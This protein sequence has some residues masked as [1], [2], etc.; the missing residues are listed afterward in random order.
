MENQNNKSKSELGNEIIAKSTAKASGLAALP[1]PIL[2]VAGIIF[3]QVNM[4]E[5]LADLYNIEIENKN[6][7]F[8]SSVASSVITKLISELAGSAA[9]ASKMDKLFGGSLIK[10]SITGFSTTVMGEIY[11]KHFSNGGK[12]ET[13]DSGAVVDYVQHE[14]AS[15]NLSIQNLSSKLVNSV[16][17]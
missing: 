14:I 16:T 3:V 13:I 1:I 11:K 2:D 15:D 17:S 7:L 9:A 5:K 6:K 8:L 4:V 12:L 10:A